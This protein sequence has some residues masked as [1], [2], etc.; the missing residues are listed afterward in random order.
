MISIVIR[1]YNEELYLRTCLQSICAQKV[2]EPFE[3][4]LVDSGS[5]DNTLFIAREHGCT[6]VEIDKS[7]FTFGLALNMGI[8]QAFGDICV[9]LSAHCVPCS[10]DWL[11][12]IV[13]S[14]RDGTADLA[15]GAQYA[16][17]N[18]RCSEYNYFSEN[19]INEKCPDNEFPELFFNNGNSAFKK[20]SWRHMSFNELASAQ[21]DIEFATYHVKNGAKIKFSPNAGVT[22][23]H[24]YS[25]WELYER[26]HK[27]FKANVIVKKFDKK[28]LLK[29]IFKFPIRVLDD[30]SLSIK[31]KRFL[32]AFPG[33][34]CFRLI[35]FYALL[36]TLI[37]FNT[38]ANEH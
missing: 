16:D 6:I 37:F 24:N 4:I 19:Y 8:A 22:H 35:E 18:S 3:I 26:L 31:R 36:K 17:P 5:T 20:Q 34:I 9:S 10:Q 11:E 2:K 27:D 29:K 1:A 32:R 21:E 14:I 13:S 28:Q 38:I 30:F 33:I 12:N 15:F 25:N 7:S 23:Y